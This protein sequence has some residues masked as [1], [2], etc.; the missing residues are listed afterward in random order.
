ME[1][2]RRTLRQRCAEVQSALRS[3]ESSSSHLGAELALC[4]GQLSAV[5][6]RLDHVEEVSEA[7]SR[8]HG[9]LQMTNADLRRDLD[10]SEQQVETFLIHFAGRPYRRSKDFA[11]GPWS[12]LCFQWDG[13]C[14]VG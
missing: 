12:H 2:E 14:G 1:E 4:R 3:A 8:R 5:Q 11:L 7:A 6:S 9:E 10:R 13:A